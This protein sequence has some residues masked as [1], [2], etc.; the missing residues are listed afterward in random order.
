MSKN[1]G[2]LVL[3]IVLLVGIVLLAMIY[4]TKPYAPGTNVAEFA[5]PQATTTVELAE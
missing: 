4:T 1:R 2:S 3:I 5:T